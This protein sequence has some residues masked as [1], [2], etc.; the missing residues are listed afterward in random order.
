MKRLLFLLFIVSSAFKAEAKKMVYPIEV[1]AGSA[2]LIVIGEISAVKSNS[3]SFKIS[4]TLKG[5]V[6][7]IITVNMFKEWTCDSRFGK[8][9]TGEKLCLFLKNVNSNWEI[10][11][12][13][14]GEILIS[15][16]SITLGNEEYK[17]I[18]YQYNPYKLPI[19]EFK[20]GIREFCK[21]YKLIGD[22]GY[23][24]KPPYF[25]QTGSDKQVA[26]FKKSSKFSA[27]LFQKLTPYPKRKIKIAS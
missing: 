3:Y 22:Y 1:I 17:H 11:N 2:D 23:Y 14:T 21:C 25:L 27:W 8:P 7:A 19:T 26:D 18:D 15:N 10:I 13:S 5:K 12:G 16:N 24:D 4:E 9:K 6:Y 20:N